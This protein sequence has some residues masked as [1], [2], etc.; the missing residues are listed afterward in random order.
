MPTG[1]TWERPL[2]ALL[3]QILVA[4]TIEFDND[5]E[6]RMRDRGHPGALSLVVWSNLM[7]FLAAG[8]LPVRNLAAEAL[9]PESRVR[10][11]LGCLERWGFVALQ[12]GVEDHRRIASR[13]LRDGWGSGRGIRSDWLVSLTAKGLEASEI[14]PPLFAEIE[15]RW[16]AR[17]GPGQIASF[18]SALE[19]ILHH[20]DLELPQAL[21]G[22]GDV[23]LAYPARAA[24]RRVPLPLP[25]LLAQLLL[26]FT[27][28]F[29]RESPAPLILCAN[30][31]RVLSEQPIPV[32]DLPRLTGGSPETCGIGW[33]L[34]PYVNVEPDRSARRGKVVSLTPR[35]LEIQRSYRDLVS[36]IEKRW[37]ARFGNDKFR[38]LRDSLL[39]LFRDRLLLSQGLLPNE[40]TV[41]A[42]EQAP[43]LGRRDIGA[44]ARQRKRDLVA[45]TEMF[46]SDPAGTL[47][48]Y[49]LWDMNRGF[50]P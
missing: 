2:S 30:T 6:R 27:I 12:A 11:E 20:I 45:Q 23:P 18:R 5:F 22:Y 34:K 14:W 16:Q 17:F 46:V 38:R 19:D 28:E 15:Q 35:G 48:H 25:A 42:G 13:I 41:R 32:A 36:E 44:A 1:V 31:L 8:S 10:F 37:A 47:P 3:S 49:P 29:N 21:P 39:E 4:F 26:A 7:R 9:A 24:G 40:G 43:S 33:Q 50:G